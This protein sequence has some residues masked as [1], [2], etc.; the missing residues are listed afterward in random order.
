MVNIRKL[1]MELDTGAAVSIISDATRKALFPDKKLHKSEGV[2][3]TYTD[4]P[5]QVLGNLNVRVKYGSQENLNA[6][7]I[8]MLGKTCL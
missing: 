3:K 1:K 8:P 4:E 2:L 6:P 7:N 5:M